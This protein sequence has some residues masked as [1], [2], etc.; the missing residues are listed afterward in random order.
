MIKQFY[1]PWWIHTKDP[2]SVS[3]E[4]YNIYMD[5]DLLS[6]EDI[7]LK[8]QKHTPELWDLA[9]NYAV[10][11][12][13]LDEN[14]KWVYPEWNE[15][16]KEFYESTSNRARY[17]LNNYKDF[18]PLREKSQVDNL[19]ISFGEKWGYGV[20]ESFEQ[21]GKV[22]LPSM[23]ATGTEIASSAL[24]SLDDLSKNLDLAFEKT[25]G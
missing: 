1:A 12:A 9:G 24:R 20:D 13:K 14:G 18:E 15:E 2:L 6:D 10:G 5:D 7:G 8:I 21:A 25:F 19:N 16:A 4:P 17:L 23:L 11:Q 3:E 22:G